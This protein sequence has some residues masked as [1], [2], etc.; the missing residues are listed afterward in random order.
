VKQHRTRLATIFVAAVL[1]LVIVS[2]WRMMTAP[3]GE[4]ATVAAVRP[5]LPSMVSGSGRDWRESDP[6]QNHLG[7]LAPNRFARSSDEWQGMLHA[8]DDIWP[9]A[10]GFCTRAKACIDG[11]CVPCVVDTECMR[12]ELCV[13]G[14]CV[15]EQRVECHARWD[16]SETDALCVLSGYTSMDPRGN[17]NMQATCL[18]PVGGDEAVDEQG[19]VE[20]SRQR[21]PPPTPERTVAT[22][23]D[24]AME[25]LREQAARRGQNRD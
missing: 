24:R 4:N 1:V 5:S 11:T 16:C 23:A 2:G 3:D 17:A 9:C 18:R 21:E 25:I 8:E 10:E 12:E 20:L 13:L 22:P 7:A 14:H 15:Q 19:H 6:P